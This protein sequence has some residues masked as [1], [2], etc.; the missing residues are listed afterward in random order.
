[1]NPVFLTAGMSLFR[2]SRAKMLGAILPRFNHN[3]RLAL[4]PNSEVGLWVAATPRR[5][6]VRATPFGDEASPLLASG[7]F[8]VRA[9]IWIRWP[10]GKITTCPIPVGANEITVDTGRI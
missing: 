6:K 5:R 9:Q 7:S 2:I 8:G 3:M 4:N 1:M 10:G